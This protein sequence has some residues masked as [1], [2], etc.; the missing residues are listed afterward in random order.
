MKACTINK[1]C[2]YG[3][4]VLSKSTFLTSSIPDAA[5]AIRNTLEDE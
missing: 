4:G 5:A 1:E 2:G 3:K